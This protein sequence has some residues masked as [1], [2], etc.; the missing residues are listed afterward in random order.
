MTVSYRVGT[1]GG[2]SG[3][4]HTEGH[5]G[6]EFTLYRSYYIRELIEFGRST[7]GTCGAGSRT[8]SII[9]LPQKLKLQKAK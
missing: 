9:A 6:T 2:P 8:N 4:I 3:W 7:E 1:L 5:W